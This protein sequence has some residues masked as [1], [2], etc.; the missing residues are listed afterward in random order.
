MKCAYCIIPSIRGA[1][2]SRSPHAV[3]DEAERLLEGGYREL[4]LCGIRLGGYRSEGFRLH[5]L[6]E[7]LLTRFK[8]AYRVRLSSL[9]PAEVTP[10]LLEVMAADRRVARHL[11]LPLQS[12]DREVLRSMRRPYTP[13]R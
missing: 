5:D 7:E 13:E 9:N 2:R 1:E 4:V 11:H 12:G 3:F 8:G 10:A 6:L